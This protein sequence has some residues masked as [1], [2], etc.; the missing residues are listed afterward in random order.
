[1]C[2]PTENV[3]VDV[4]LTQ[5]SG[6]DAAGYD[7]ATLKT[8]SS[9]SASTDHREYARL[10]EGDGGAILEHHDRPT[11]QSFHRRLHGKGRM[12]AL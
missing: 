8:D 9:N 10:A 6:R 3:S 5:V 1:M 11:L 12:I 2:S 4:I 7:G